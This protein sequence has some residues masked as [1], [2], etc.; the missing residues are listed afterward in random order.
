[1]RTPDVAIATYRLAGPDD[2]EAVHALI[3]SA[4][5]GES[6]RVGWTTEADLLDDT[7][8]NATDVGAV[9][10][11]PNS[12][13]LLAIDQAGGLLACCQL[14]RRGDTAYFGMF[15]V[16]PTLQ[17]NGIGAAVL[18]EAER[19]ARE[20]WQARVLEMQVIDVRTELIEWYERRGYRRTCVTYPFPHD[21]A[22]DRGGR[23]ELRFAVLAKAL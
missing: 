1:V 6:S 10:M 12:E 18:I 19:L 14:E 11:S 21:E 20:Q 22:D 8:T 7:R 3:E 16:R 13:L 23:P 2:V 17:G 9:V 5:R 15:A 4:Y